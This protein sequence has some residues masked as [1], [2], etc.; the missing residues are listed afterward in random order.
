MVPRQYRLKHKKDFDA[1][2]SVGRFVGGD[3]VQ[4]KIWKIN[5]ETF[6]KRKYTTDD[7]KIGFV[8]SVKVHKRAVIRNRMKRRMREVVRLM[9]K[10]QALLPGYL[11]AVMAKP[12]IVDATYDEISESITAVFQKAGIVVL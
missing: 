6:P 3:C 7:L 11:I 5:S 8:V 4:L 10:E 9:L 12:Q 1:L 2:F